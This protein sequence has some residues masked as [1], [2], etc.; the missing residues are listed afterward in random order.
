MK[1]V[2]TRH[3]EI[4]DLHSHVSGQKEANQLLSSLYKRSPAISALVTQFN[5]VAQKLPK[6]YSISLYSPSAFQ[7]ALKAE[8]G[9]SIEMSQN[10]LWNYEIL[11]ARYTPASEARGVNVTDIGAD[12]FI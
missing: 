8:T 1:V 6:E 5:N 11:Q 3:S 9:D 12:V 2:A 10:A 4:K 7:P